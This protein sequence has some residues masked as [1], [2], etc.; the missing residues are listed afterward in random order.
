M[1]LWQRFELFF[2]KEVGSPSDLSYKRELL[3]AILRISQVGVGEGQG[4]H[5]RGFCRKP[6]RSLD[7]RVVGQVV[8]RR[9]V[10]D[11]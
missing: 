2:S 5:F 3:G 7:Q 6:Y 11:V 4:G 8:L 9:Q 1:R 10:L